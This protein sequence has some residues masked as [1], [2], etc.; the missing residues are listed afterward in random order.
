M[1]EIALLVLG[2]LFGSILGYIVFTIM[3]YLDSRR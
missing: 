1:N 3:D 2:A